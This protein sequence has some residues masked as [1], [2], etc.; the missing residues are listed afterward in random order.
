[1]KKLTYYFKVGDK[2]Y[3]EKAESAGQAMQQINRRVMDQL[4]I[5]PFAWMDSVLPR[6]YYCSAGNYWD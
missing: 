4:N 6:T 1:M 2:E 5:G 3:K